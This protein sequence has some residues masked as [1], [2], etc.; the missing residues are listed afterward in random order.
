M[1]GG[2]DSFTP[3]REHHMAEFLKFT[4]SNT[5]HWINLSS[6]CFV[7]VV[8]KDETALD[9]VQFTYAGGQVEAFGEQSGAKEALKALEDHANAEP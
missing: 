2:A 1:A 3:A 5:Q 6:V 8:R 9:M 4:F 7:R